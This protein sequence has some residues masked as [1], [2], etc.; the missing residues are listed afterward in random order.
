MFA[1]TY[2]Y[3]Y[4]DICIDIQIHMYT[5]LYIHAPVQTDIHKDYTPRRKYLGESV[6]Q[7]C[8]YVYTYIRTYIHVY[9]Y[10]YIYIRIYTNVFIHRIP[11]TNTIARETK[12]WLRLVGSLKLHVSFAKEPYKRDNILQKRP[13]I[14]RS[15]LI[16]ATPYLWKTGLQICIYVCKYVCVF[17]YGYIFIRIY[18][19]C[20]FACMYMYVRTCM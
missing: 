19:V 8:V 17:A 1:Y 4:T 3:T 6:L 7:I 10:T 9:I 20:I 14:L 5:R 15:L 16:V 18:T 13:R 12:G 11:Q 2:T